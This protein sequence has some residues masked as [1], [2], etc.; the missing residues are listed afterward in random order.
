MRS[1]SV[2]SLLLVALIASPSA[3]TPPRN[4]ILITLDGARHQEIFTG[5]D[6]EIVQSTLKDGQTL[7]QSPLYKRYWA[8]TP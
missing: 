6:A 7:E 3:Q 1:S 2:L 8:P 5:L 4:V